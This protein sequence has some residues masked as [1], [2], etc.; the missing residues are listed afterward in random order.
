MTKEEISGEKAV[1]M[2]YSIEITREWMLS[3]EMTVSMKVRE[4]HEEER[5]CG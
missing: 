1:L 5:R 4:K 2:K 3:H